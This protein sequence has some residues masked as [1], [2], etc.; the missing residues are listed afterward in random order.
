MKLLRS[1]AVRYCLL[2]TILMLVQVGT[3]RGQISNIDF[4]FSPEYWFSA[5]GFPFDHHKTLADDEGALLYDF[6]PGPY[7][8]PATR[9]FF[10]LDPTLPRTQTLPDARVPLLETRFGGDENIIV[11]TYALEPRGAVATVRVGNLRRVNGLTGTRAWANPPAHADPAFRNVA[12]GTNRPIEYELSVPE[13]E[14]KQIALGFCESYR[15]KEGMR[16]LLIDVEGSDPKLFDPL[17]GGTT[18]QPRV[19][20][21]R[22]YDSDRDGK[23]HI[24]ILSPEGDPNTILNALWVFSGD[25]DVDADA[26]I[27]GRM[28]EVAEEYLDAGAGP[29][30]R[31]RPPRFDVVKL[32]ASEARN[33]ILRIATG[34]DIRIADG[35]VLAD[36]IPF[37]RTWPG[38][39]SWSVDSAGAT[40]TFV[41][42]DKIL[43]VVQDGYG[44]AEGFPDKSVAN[45]ETAVRQ[46]WLEQVDIPYSRITVPDEDLQEMINASIRTVYQMIENV[47]GKPQAQPGAGLYRGLWMHDSVY[48]I[49]LFAQLGNLAMSRKLIDRLLEFQLPSGQA[50]IM[51]PNLIHRETPLLAWLLCRFA[52]LSNDDEFLREHWPRVQAAINYMRNLRE[53]TLQEGAPNYGLTPSGFAD[54]GIHGVQPEY[55]SVNWILIALPTVVRAA[56]RLGKDGDA[57]AWRELYE[58]F[59]SSWHAAAARD[60]RSDS[61][62]NAYLPIRVGETGWDDPPPRAQWS[63]PEAMVFGEHISVSDSLAAGTLGMLDTYEHQGLISN[64]GWLN[65]G[66]WGYFGGMLAEAYLRMGDGRRAAELLYAMANHASPVYTWPEEQMPVGHGRRTAGDFPHAWSSSTIPRLVI[67]LMA[68]EDGQDLTLLRGIPEAW[69]TRHGGEDRIISLNGVATR[70]GVLDKL[71]VTVTGETAKIFISGIHGRMGSEVRIDWQAFERAGFGTGDAPS[72]V[73]GQDYSIELSRR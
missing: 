56:E 51:H 25:A 52:E 39:D 28:N 10:Q 49:D 63:L 4:R 16:K 27:A 71:E 19:V 55:A 43:A 22:G 8:K 59:L 42:V 17:L 23:I 54:G 48:Y 34:R 44:P 60:V 69:L 36:E 33:R 13:G 45:D 1:I 65:N 57:G 64:V 2:L 61:L 66:I 46:F 14:E 32:E 70:F 37:V 9:V 24:R 3:C 5:I 7:V 53:Q 20:L 15:T 29:Q 30:V 35:I 38:P 12:W 58:E 21:R 11:K 62:G 18:N 41:N 50:R 31:A 73:W 67:R 47:D 40:L 6:G 68:F 72:P 26:I